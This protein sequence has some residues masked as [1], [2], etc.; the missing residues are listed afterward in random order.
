M[1]AKAVLRLFDRGRGV[2]SQKVSGTN[3][4]MRK[5]QN[6]TTMATILEYLSIVYLT[7]QLHKCLPKHPPPAQPLDNGCTDQ[8]DQIF[9][10]KEQ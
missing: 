6:P 3:R 8:W 4:N 7:G 2:L 10:T 9:T 1:F 5:K